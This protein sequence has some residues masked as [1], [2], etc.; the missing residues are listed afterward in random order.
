MNSRYDES[1]DRLDLMFRG[2]AAMLIPRKMIAG[3]ERASRSKLGSVLVS[4]AGNALS[5]PSL[6]VD[7]YVP[8]L[9]ERVFGSRLFSATTRRRAEGRDQSGI[10]GYLLSRSVP[11]TSASTGSSHARRTSCASLRLEAAPTGSASLR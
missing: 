7:V 1:E 4:P 11:A 3:L 6:D 2:G 8:A 9:V 5:W 10:L